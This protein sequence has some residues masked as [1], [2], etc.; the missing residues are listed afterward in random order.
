MA[1]P[2]RFDRP[3]A[4][5]HV[6]NRGQGHSPLFETQVDVERLHAFLASVIEEGQLRVLAYCIMSTHLHLLVESPLGAISAAIQRAASLYAQYFNRTRARDGHAFKGRFFSRLI[7]DDVHLACATGY[8]DWNPVAADMVGSPE[9]YPHGSARFYAGSEPG[10]HWL[11][12]ARIEALLCRMTGAPRYRPD[13]YPELWRMTR[14]AGARSLVERALGSPQVRLAPLAVL[15]RGGPAFVQQWLVE[16]LMREEG[17]H[18]PCLVVAG[19]EILSR[20]PAKAP[21]HPTG[22]PIQAGIVE[23]AS[24]HAGLLRGSA[25]WTTTEVARSLGISQASASRAAELHVVRM[26]SDAAYARQTAEILASAIDG[27]YG[28]LGRIASV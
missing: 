16:N 5:H 19:E 7:E 14:V 1:R 10:P 17:R 4:L 6:T 12:R 22:S 23:W 13:L 9:A 15:M 2:R 20:L 24:M 28:S 21:T 11:N 25:G 26:K 8:V 18:E 3:N 27:V